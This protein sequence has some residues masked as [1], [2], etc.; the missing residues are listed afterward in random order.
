M[1][2]QINAQRTS[3]VHNIPVAAINLQTVLVGVFVVAAHAEK[4]ARTPML[5]ISKT[6]IITN[7]QS[8]KL[9]T[10]YYVYSLMYQHYT[11]DNLHQ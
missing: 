9:F 8:I 10:I 7:F 2:F 4:F 3:P 1:S 11:V 6:K 5:G